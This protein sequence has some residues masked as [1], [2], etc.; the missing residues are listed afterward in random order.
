MNVVSF[1]PSD[2]QETAQ[3]PGRIKLSSGALHTLDRSPVR[4]RLMARS[5]GYVMVKKP[6]AAPFVLSEK[7]WAALDKH[8][9][10]ERNDDKN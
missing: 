5:G 6:R 4:I 7:E 2:R 1:D 8:V 10:Q 9:P 3:P